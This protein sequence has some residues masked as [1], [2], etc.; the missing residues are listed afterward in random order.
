[1]RHCLEKKP[2]DRPQSAPELFD[3]FR[4]AVEGR[5]PASPQKLQE[6]SD[7]KLPEI[8]EE[9]IPPPPAPWLAWLKRRGGILGVA[10]LACLALVPLVWA[11]MR[12]RHVPPPLLRSECIEFLKNHGL[13]PVAGTALAG[14]GCPETIERTADRR[15]FVWHQGLYLPE[16]YQPDTEKGTAGRLPLALLRKDGSRFLLI[17]GGE[18][19]MGAFDKNI[20]EFLGEEKPGHIVRLSDF[21]LQET[22]VTFGEFDRFC[23]ETKRGR[24]DAELKDGFYFA[25]DALHM[26][27]SEDELRKHPVVG[28]PRKLAELYAHHVGGELPSEAQ[29]EFAARSR[30]KNQLHVWADRPVAQECERSP[31]HRLGIETR[32]VGNST[33]DRTEQGVLDL[34]GNVREWCRDVWKVYPQIE[35]ATR[36][37]ADPDRR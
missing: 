3:L 6:K 32:P 36:P 11:M 20:K 24:N 27:M 21:Y 34:A 7:E 31:G 5:E 17:T 2:E 35:P 26:K 33:D 23:Q 29:W 18:F 10:V 19:V 12:N 28:V 15:R 25:W 22:E 13:Q 37:R 1:M 16:D 14:G 8:S 30:G 9:V 4:A